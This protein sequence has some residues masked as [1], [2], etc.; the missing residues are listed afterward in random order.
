MDRLLLVGLTLRAR[1]GVNPGGG[2]RSGLL[3]HRYHFVSL[4]QYRYAHS[5]NKPPAQGT[6]AKGHQHRRDQIGDHV[7]ITAVRVECVCCI[8]LNLAS[9]LVAS[10]IPR[11]VGYCRRSNAHPNAVTNRKRRTN[12]VVLRIAPVFV[13]WTACMTAR[14]N[15]VM[16]LSDGASI[17]VAIQKQCH[18]CN[19]Y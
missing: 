13:R 1:K 6:G 12:V 17:Y 3:R 19:A 16:H 8:V 11:F 9:K 4:G 14:L 10:I 18:L 5:S 2:D 15:E 7:A